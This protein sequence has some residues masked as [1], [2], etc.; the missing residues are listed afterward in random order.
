MLKANCQNAFMWYSDD[1]AE[2]LV[3]DTKLAKLI[4]LSDVQ[5]VLIYTST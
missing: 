3:N 5:V 4:V 1:N 2:L